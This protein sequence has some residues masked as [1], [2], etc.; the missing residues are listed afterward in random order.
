M[1]LP[2]LRRV[3]FFSSNPASDREHQSPPQVCRCPSPD[4]C[5]RLSASPSDLLEHGLRVTALE[6]QVISRLRPRPPDRVPGADAVDP[7]GGP[8]ITF[9]AQRGSSRSRPLRAAES[10]YLDLRRIASLRIGGHDE[11]GPSRES[12]RLF[13]DIRSGPRGALIEDKEKR[14][15]RTVGPDR[16]HF[17]RAVGRR[18][19]RVQSPDGEIVLENEASACSRLSIPRGAHRNAFQGRRRSLPR[20]IEADFGYAVGISLQS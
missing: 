17:K 1:V 8:D 12:N 4:S 5:S 2:K 11:R 20:E 19:P 15:N 18:A 10:Q 14:L 7:S 16:R 6:E 3:L 9:D 13:E